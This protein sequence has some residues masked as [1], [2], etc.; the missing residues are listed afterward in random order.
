MPELLWKAYIDFEFEER[1]RERT[2]SLYRR[3][4]ER[5]GHVKVWI[6]FALFEAAQMVGDEDEEGAEAVGGME[7]DPEKARA[8]FQEG[9]NNLRQRGLKEEASHPV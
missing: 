1:E 6:A 4:L 2:R 8:V 7:G 3:L 5:T 9:Y